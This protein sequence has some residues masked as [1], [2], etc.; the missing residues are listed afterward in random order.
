MSRTRTTLA[1]LALLVFAASVLY[2]TTAGSASAGWFVEG[3]ELT[4]SA[5]LATTAAVDEAF[6]L[7]VPSVATTV[8]CSGSTLSST[9]PEIVAPSR[10]AMASITFS[11]CKTEGTGGC[12]LAAETISSL[13]L[14]AELTELTYPEDKAAFTPKTKKTFAAIHFEGGTCAL[15]GIQPV[16]AAT[17]LS[18]TLPTGQEEKTLQQIKVKTTKGDLK[19]GLNEAELTGAALIKLGSGLELV[20]AADE[21]LTATAAGTPPQPVGPS[22]PFL[23]GVGVK[24]RNLIIINPGAIRRQFLN[25]TPDAGTPG[26]LKVNQNSNFGLAKPGGSDFC[27]D[28]LAGGKSCEVEITSANAGKNGE[29]YLLYGNAADPKILNFNINS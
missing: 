9:S 22:K 12:T 1:R 21:Q 18:A 26:E 23:F 13:P 25:G 17:K 29:Y 16:T 11:S 28:I 15:A 27:G 5:A 6:K 14:L 3:S 10:I 7:E 24:S 2:M 8:K 4:G 20:F 19:L